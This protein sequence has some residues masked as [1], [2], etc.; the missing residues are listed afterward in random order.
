MYNITGKPA[1]M[2]QVN[3]DAIIIREDLQIQDPKPSSNK[4]NTINISE[5][6]K[7]KLFFESLRKPQFQRSTWEWTPERVFQLVESFTKDDLIP[8]IILWQGHGYNFVIDGAHRLSALIGWVNNDYGMG[9]ISQPFFGTNLERGQREKSKETKKLIEDAIGSYEDIVWAGAN[10]DKADP[11]R[12]KIANIISARAIDLQWVPGNASQAEASFFKINEAAAPLDSTEKRLLMARNKPMAIASRAIIRAGSGHKY[13]GKFPAKNQEQIEEIAFELNDWLFLPQLET[14]LKTLDIP[15]AGKSYSQTTQELILNVVNFSNNIKIVDAS[16]IKKTEEFPEQ[17]IDDESSDGI[18]TINYL[19]NTKKMLANLTGKQPCSLGLHPAIYFYSHQARY[20]I[21]AFMAMLSLIRD[22]ENRKQ[23]MKYTMVRKEFEEF[24]WKHKS[25]VNQATPVWGSGAKGY[26]NMAKLFDFII[27]L[28]LGG[29]DE[30]DKEKKEADILKALDDNELY[31]FFKPGVKDL[32][33]K[34]RTKMSSETKS[35]VFMR[36]G[37][38]SAL[39]C[40][41]CG[42]FLHK[43]SMNVDHDLEIENGGIGNAEN[44]HLTHFYCNS[45]KKDLKGA[46]FNFKG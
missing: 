6:E 11:N 32:N 27:Q 24:L 4:T 2:S 38:E 44:G 34:H 31:K 1:Y 43:N 18:D 26:N 12:V 30:I 39:R 35:E 13:W 25:L 9:N 8:A 28:L 33:P 37:I 21:T 10:R 19:V 42:G 16:R 40:F 3:L 29:K 20:Q 23:L 15:L 14:P 46:G 45:I 7:G 5:L 17:K 41:I 22:Y 36:Q